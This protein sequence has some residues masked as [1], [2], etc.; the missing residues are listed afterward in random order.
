M[1]EAEDSLLD[2]PPSRSRTVGATTASRLAKLPLPALLV[3]FL[4][5]IL[6]ILTYRILGSHTRAVLDG[7]PMSSFLIYTGWNWLLIAVGYRWISR[8]QVTWKDL[9]FTSFRFRDMWLALAGALVGLWV[10]FPLSGFIARALG[11]APMKG[12]GYSLVGSFDI[13]GA[14]LAAV[15]LAT[16]AEEILFRGFLLNTLRGKM[17]S[18][19]AVGL[20]GVLFFTVIHLPHFGWAGMLFIV[21]WSPLPV[22]LF[23]WR[24]SIYPSYVMHVLNNF[25]AYVIVPLFLR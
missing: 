4:P 11:L 7:Y 15:F 25:F 20:I 1:P 19:W 6:T 21:L 13:I 24:R 16:L 14:L 17:R 2:H 9:G 23:L 12:M 22:G 5:V 10:V 3:V 18:L 8:R